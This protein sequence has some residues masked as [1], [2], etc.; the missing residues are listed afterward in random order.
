MIGFSR[1]TTTELQ[2][3]EKRVKTLEAL[4]RENNIK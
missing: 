2:Y 1:Y 4:L 3:A